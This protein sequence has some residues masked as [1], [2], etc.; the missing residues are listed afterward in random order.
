LDA[1]QTENLINCI[2][3]DHSTISN[4]TLTG[5]L[6][7]FGGGLY[8]YNSNLS[9]LN[10]T[11]AGNEAS[12]YGG[13]ICIQYASPYLSNITVSDNEAEKG[14]GIRIVYSS[15]TIMN[16]TIRDNYAY[17]D[18]GGMH[19]RG[20]V[21]IDVQLSGVQSMVPI[22]K[23]VQ[24]INNVAGDG[25]GGIYNW[26]YSNP[27]FENV[28]IAK[29]Y[30]PNDGGGILNYYSCN[31]NFNNITIYGNETLTRGGGIFL[32]HAASAII[33][34]SI[35]WNNIPE[36][37]HFSVNN[38]DYPN[39][40][41]L[42]NSALQGGVEGIVTN[43]N[44]T[45]VHGTG[46]CLGEDPSCGLAVTESDCMLL[47]DFYSCTWNPII[48]EM[49]VIDSNPL[50]VDTE[51][52]DY[53]LQTGSP[54]IDAGRADLDGDGTDDIIDYCGFAPDMGA[55]EY[56]TEECEELS[57]SQET[58]LPI[59][60]SLNS[61]YPNPFNPVTTIVYDVPN[62]SNVSIK[63][64]DIKGSEVAELIYGNFTIGSHTVSWDASEHPSGV[65]FVK[66][67]AGEYISTKKLMLVK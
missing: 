12:S 1:Q 61:A 36:E 45:V 28:L 24:I 9:L 37:I 43:N 25:G 64:Y 18:G 7:E 19:L 26:E 51:N 67:I 17:D 54:C 15:P 55:Y 66:M 35:L 56:I 65:Y 13:G 22:F 29:N 40:A 39:E 32:S 21:D 38:S 41:T 33:T 44:G 57:F 30:A 27:I 3:I 34:N 6:A 31:P 58:P 60:C 4:L 46:E 49:I 47:G 11:I 8:V 48:I 23:N 20:K 59:H 5:G 2:S 10:L 53:T 52:G 14:G 63:I 50:F 62:M 16:C 42:I